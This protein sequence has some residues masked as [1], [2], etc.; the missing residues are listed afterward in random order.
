MPGR[1]GTR[2]VDVRSL[3][4]SRWL[5]ALAPRRSW[6]AAREWMFLRPRCTA[7]SRCSRNPMSSRSTTDPM[8]WDDT[9][10]RS[11][12]QATTTISSVCRVAQ[13]R[14][15]RCPDMLRVNSR[16]SLILWEKAQASEF[17]TTSS[18]SKVCVRPA[19]DRH[20]GAYLYRQTIR[21]IEGSY[22]ETSTS[23]E[24]PGIIRIIRP[25]RIFPDA[26]AVTS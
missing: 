8:E 11:G 22:A 23:T 4:R 18:R 16:R 15:S 5:R 6:P 19:T 7:H 10:S 13:S 24:S 14:T 3:P 25:L 1:S 9:S 26:R 21:P 17:L 2:A 20:S 12:S